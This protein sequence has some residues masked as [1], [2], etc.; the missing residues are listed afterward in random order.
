MK[1]K[2][3]E[4]TKRITKRSEA[5]RSAYLERIEQDRRYCENRPV[6]HC[7]PASNL[8]HA[9]ASA[10]PQAKEALFGRPPEIGII[11]SYNDMLSA[12]APYAS[13]PDIIK[14][15]VARRGAVAQVAG[16][17]PAMCDGVTQGEPGMDLSLMSRDVIAMSVAVALSHNLFD[18]A[19]L[20]GVCDKIV[21]GL[22]MGALQFGHLPMAL[23]PAGPMP[24]GIPNREKARA[25]QLFAQGEISREEMLKIEAKAYHSQGT[26]TFYGTANSNQLIAEVM[27]LHLPGASFVHPQDQM[28]QA[29]T[30][31]AAGRICELTRFGNE[32]L[33]I[34][35]LIDEKSIVNAMVALLATGGSTNQTMH[36]VAI[37]RAAGIRIDWNDFSDLSEAVPF[38]VRIYPNGP[39]D[40]NGF[41]AAGGVAAMIT[42]LLDAGCLHEDVET[43]AG[44][45]LIRYTLAPALEDGR[46]SYGTEQVRSKNPEVISSASSPFDGSGGLKVL[47][48]NLGRAVIKTSALEHGSDTVVEARALVFDDQHELSAA[49][50]RGE[51]DRDLVAVV[52]FQGPQ[53]NGMPELH[54]LITPLSIVMDRGFKAALVTD[55]R[56][57]GASGRVPSAIHVSPEAFCG[58]LLAKVRDGDMIRLDTRNG[59]L[60][61][62]VPEEELA[63]RPLPDTD[64][65]G[66]HFG[67][68]R[69][70]FSP[71]RRCA[72]HAE[73]GASAIFTYDQEAHGLH[74]KQMGDN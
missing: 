42:E 10:E 15:E 35:R 31:M 44:T 33:P 69:Q 74:S 73:Q 51:L 57:S 47:K 12:H 46:I 24:S 8:A 6:R 63:A 4:V 1:S 38:L 16:G 53:A 21:P 23:V 65:T 26:C 9:M 19:L 13:Y 54:K 59:L 70:I 34:G 7:L 28:R 55:G 43:I 20:L 5:S 37:A 2:I 50:E 32:Y 56:L 36:L 62:L 72:M 60:E 29:F 49:F 52:R 3:L 17:V 67:M 27:G 58:G 71:L 66:S 64:L 41:Q 68:G 45:G 18:G 22:L 14:D 40:I 30:R 25:R 61:L 11:T 39:E 48:G